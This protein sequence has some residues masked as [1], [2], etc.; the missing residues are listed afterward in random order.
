MVTHD[1]T[2]HVWLHSASLHQAMRSTGFD[3][4]YKAG[5]FAVI[6]SF[7]QSCD[8]RVLVLDVGELFPRRSVIARPFGCRGHPHQP[9]FGFFHSC[10]WR[11]SI[12]DVSELFPRRSAVVWLPDCRGHPRFRKLYSIVHVDVVRVKSYVNCLFD[13]A[14]VPVRIT[15]DNSDFQLVRA[16]YKFAFTFRLKNLVRTGF[17]PLLC[18]IL[19]KIS[20]SSSVIETPKASAIF[21]TTSSI[22]I[23]KLSVIPWNSKDSSLES[24]SYYLSSPQYLVARLHVRSCSLAHF[25]QFYLK[26]RCVLGLF[27]S[28]LTIY[29]LYLGLLGVISGCLSC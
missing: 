11:I 2:H 28:S 20:I 18:G 15:I 27:S 16:L 29:L 5:R 23:L 9:I 6:G 1:V 8:W 10:D 26:R 14:S 12:L 22:D 17:S 4:C 21:P 25:V 7:F 19:C 3:C 13:P 24:C